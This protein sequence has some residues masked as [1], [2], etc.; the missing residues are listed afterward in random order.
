MADRV[1]GTAAATDRGRLVGELARTRPLQRSGGDQRRCWPVQT[2]GVP[3][4]LVLGAHG[5]ARCA[6]DPAHR[7]PT[8]CARSGAGRDLELLP[9]TEGV[10]GIADAA[11]AGALGQRLRP[12]LFEGDGLAGTGR[13]VAEDSRQEVGVVVGSRAPGNS[14]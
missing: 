5:A 14:A 1:G 9:T 6:T 7:R 13:A 2:V 4:R 8:S 10:S 11:T 3:A 12:A